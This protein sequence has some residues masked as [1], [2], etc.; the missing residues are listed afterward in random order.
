MSLFGSSVFCQ[1]FRQAT[2]PGESFLPT[3][4]LFAACRLLNLRAPALDK[5]QQHNHKQHA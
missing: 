4:A 5:E 1:S 2:S 3:Q